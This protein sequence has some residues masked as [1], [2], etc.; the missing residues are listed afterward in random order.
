MKDKSEAVSYE[1]DVDGRYVRKSQKTERRGRH[2]RK[3]KMPKSCS[4]VNREHWHSALFIA[5]VNCALHRCRQRGN[6]LTAT[7]AV[8]RIAKFVVRLITIAGTEEI[9]LD[10]VDFLQ[11]EF[12]AFTC[13]NNTH[14]WHLRMCCQCALGCLF[15]VKY[16]KG[17]P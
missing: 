14:E 4:G 2:S 10:A 13:S 11:H 7:I 16:N 5:D 15:S 8:V 17:Q 6:F 1:S 12:I 3:K 9:Q